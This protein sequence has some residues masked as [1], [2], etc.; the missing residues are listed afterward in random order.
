MARLGRDLEK[1]VSLLEGTLQQSGIEMKSPDFLPDK[2]TGTL[3]EVD[4]SLRGR[5]GSS[6]ILAI[7]ECRDRGATQDVTWIEQVIS[8][9]I[10]VNADKAM[11]VS[12]SKFS[13]PSRLKAEKNNIELRTLEEINPADVTDWFVK[14]PYLLIYRLHTNFLHISFYP[15]KPDGEEIYAIAPLFK[16]KIDNKSVSFNDIWLSISSDVQKDIPFDGCK[17]QR[18]LIFNFPNMQDRFQVSTKSGDI[19]IESLIIDAILWFTE[20]KVPSTSLKIYRDKDK[21]IAKIQDFRFN[22]NGKEH[23]LC[24]HQSEIDGT[25]KVSLIRDVE[26]N[27]S[28][29]EIDRNKI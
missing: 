5:I 25:Q 16:R 14:L 7:I 29:I 4:I 23:A 18:K 26:P 6:G 10:S 15:Q 13:E 12:S 20:E 27:N 2:D 28:P 22:I 1:V 24:F 9:S 8:K 19:D 3:R 17:L 21:D 11:A